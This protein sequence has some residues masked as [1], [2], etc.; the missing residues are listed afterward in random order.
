MAH[1]IVTYRQ[2]CI[3]IVPVLTFKLLSFFM[4]IIN[5]ENNDNVGPLQFPVIGNILQVY[6]ADSTY[7][8][9]AFVK[10]AR[11]YGNIL[12]LRIG[13]TEAGIVI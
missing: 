11:K 8:H 12:W 1:V 3:T 4:Q 6:L 9:R 10:L 5:V 7:P 13:S 2:V